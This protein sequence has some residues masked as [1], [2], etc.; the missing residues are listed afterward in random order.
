MR[1]ESLFKTSDKHH[2]KFKALSGVNG[3]ELNGILALLGLVIARFKRGMGQK[4]HQ[5]RS[6]NL[7]VFGNALAFFG[8]KCLSGINQLTKIFNSISAFFFGL[9]MTN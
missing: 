5:R 4:T 8:N 7:A 6:L 3:H 1:E 9:V 2:I